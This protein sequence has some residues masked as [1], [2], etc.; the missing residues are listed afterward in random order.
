MLKDIDVRLERAAAAIEFEPAQR[1]GLWAQTWMPQ[2]KEVRLDMGSGRG[3]F[4]IESAK[5]DPQTL[6]IGLDAEVICTACAGRAALEEQV[7]NVV[8]GTLHA[9]DLPKAFAPG[10]LS[11]IYLNFSTPFPRKKFAAQRLTYLDNLMTYRTLLCE[12]GRIELKTDSQPFR[13][14]TLTQLALAGFEVVWSTDDMRAED[15]QSPTSEYE[16][17]LVAQGAKIYALHAVPGELPESQEQTASMSLIDYMPAD[18]S[19]LTYIPFG[20]EGYVECMLNRQ[21]NQK[22]KTEAKQRKKESRMSTVPTKEEALALLDKYNKEEYHR[23]HGRIVGAVLAWY[24]QK[25]EASVPEGVEA[26]PINYWYAVG[27]LHD[28]DF[29]LYPEEHCVA[30]VKIFEDEGIDPHI[31]RNAL[32]HGWGMTGSAWEPELQMEKIL[33]A[34]DELTGLIYAAIRMRPSKSTLD[35]DAKSVKKKFKDKRFAEGC[36]RETIASGAENLGWTLDELIEGT[37][38][39]MQA[40]EQEQGGMPGITKEL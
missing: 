21:A 13:D 31:M 34:A 25:T 1:A 39:A 6:Y 10:E 14:F 18:L 4:T 8:F 22:R 16:Q 23:V 7:K 32:S 19:T 33:F 20:M 2:A 24:A 36:S 9:Q 40:Y 30:G 35:M 17:K 37:L 3:G 26:D 12:G 38:E 15:T 11:C 28:I 29:E 27:A 5:R